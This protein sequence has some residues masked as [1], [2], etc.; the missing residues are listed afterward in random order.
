MR[1]EELGESTTSSK[2]NSSFGFSTDL[3]TVTRVSGLCLEVASCLPP[4]AV[5]I[6]PG[7]IQAL[8]EEEDCEKEGSDSALLHIS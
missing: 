8:P 7:G 2:I 3:V 4:V 1:P 6:K 5:R